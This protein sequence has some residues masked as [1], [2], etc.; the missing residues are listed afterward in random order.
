MHA[1]RGVT[2]PA[3]AL[4][5]ERDKVPQFAQLHGEGLHLL[6]VTEVQVPQGHEVADAL[7]ERGEQVVGEVERGYPLGGDVSL[8]GGEFVVG[9]VEDFEGRGPLVQVGEGGEA[10]VGEVEVYQAG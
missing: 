4:Q 10:V 8:D 2:E 9:E 7:R 1:L 6:V 3:E 5:V